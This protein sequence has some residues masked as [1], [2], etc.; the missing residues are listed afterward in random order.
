MVRALVLD[1][2]DRPRVAE[3]S[4]SELKERLPEGEVTVRVHAS[5]LNYKD[6]MVVKGVG[7]LVKQY[8]HVPGI[9]FAGEVIESDHPAY[10][11]G[12]RVICT[13]WGVGERFWGGFADTARVKGDWL[14]PLP[15]GLTPWRAMALGT[16]G[17]TAMLALMTL[18]DQ[19]MHPDQAAP[20]LVTGAA[21]GVGSVAVS[22]LAHLGYEVAA[23]T[24]RPETHDDLRALGARQIVER[25]ELAEG[26]TKPL[27]TERWGACVDAVG[28]P[29]LA[30]VL[31][32]LVYGGGVAAVG[33]A[34]GHELN[35]TVMPFLLRGVNL[36]GIDSVHCPYARRV[37]AWKRLSHEMPMQTLD[38]LSHEIGLS[39]VPEQAD[40][41]LQGQ[42]KGRT[43]VD[44]TR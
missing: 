9:D 12:D 20:V 5:T 39:E 33:L 37:T 38:G 28:G 21:G 40:R 18:E 8:P 19:G 23:L 35:T 41:I 27:D 4:E 31:S 10:S 2:A 16:A 15:E 29:I 32:Q 30:R 43:V 13:G 44:P 3:L 6:G 22:V 36:L 14:V 25:A 17:L 26:R 1:D 34:G 24:G 7:K 42:V 11:P